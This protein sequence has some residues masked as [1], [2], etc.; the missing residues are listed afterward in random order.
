MSARVVVFG[1]LNMDLVAAVDRIAAPGE[2]VAGHDFATYP[3]GKGGNQALAA[4]R[5]AGGAAAVLLVGK[6][7]DDALGRQLLEFYKSVGLAT[8]A[9][10]RSAERPTGTALIQVERE[11]GQN[12]IVVVAGANGDFTPDDMAAAPLASGDI[13]L[14]QFEVPPACIATLFRR[15]RAAGTV[16]V[17]NPA[18]VAPIDAALLDLVD[19]LVL[20][21]T[22]LAALSGAGASAS[23]AWSHAETAAAARRLAAR[24]DQR[25]V[26]TLGAEGALAVAGEETYRV[27]G[28]RVTPVD[29]TG[30]GDCFVGT[31]AAALAR[32]VP[33]TL[34]LEIA[35][36]AASLSVQR[37][38]AGTSMPT[39]E[40]IAATIRPGR[41]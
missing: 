9:V 33:F 16:N 30:A 21:E 4:H 23:A 5:A 25:I 29:T 8:D 14:S 11:T 32:G 39:A 1:S 41:G 18:P 13:L 36:A 10:A 17:L 27:P 15:G 26:V 3:G 22:E 34:A 24:R 38:G 40:E 35:N 7:G 37:K 19:V 28:R 31:L 20:N 2:T 6:V 12:S